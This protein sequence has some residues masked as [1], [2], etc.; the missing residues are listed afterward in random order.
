MKMD[1]KGIQAT[2][3]VII[4]VVVIAAGAGAYV[5]A[6]NDSGEETG[7]DGDVKSI[8][9]SKVVPAG[10]DFVASINIKGIIE[11]SNFKSLMNEGLS[12]YSQTRGEIGPNDY[13]DLK[14]RFE[15][16]TGGLVLSDI[17]SVIVFGKQSADEEEALPTGLYE[18]GYYGIVFS[19]AWSENEVITAIETSNDGNE[20]TKKSY[21][22]VTVYSPQKD[23]LAQLAILNEELYVMGNEKAV[24]DVIDVN[25]GNTSGISGSLKSEMEELGSR[26]A[27]FAVDIPESEFSGFEEMS[28]AGAQ[29]VLNKI[30]MLSGSIQ[31]DSNITIT[32]RLVASDQDSAESLKDTITGIISLV[33]GMGEI[34]SPEIKEALNSIVVEQ[35]GSAVTISYETSVENLKDLIDELSNLSSSELP[36]L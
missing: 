18:D 1:N 27:S 21:K 23:G 29:N 30:D 35:D 26:L 15:N 33:K 10:I 25:K 14:E 3:I 9:T 32:I 12:L 16:E 22:E 6:S 17:N 20:M 34:D 11:D 2:I 28:P 7:A 19:A 24:K 36:T 4:I 5:I 31:S 8:E 13:Q